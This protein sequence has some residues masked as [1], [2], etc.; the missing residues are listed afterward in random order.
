MTSEKNWSSDG[1]FKIVVRDVDEWWGCLCPH[2][3]SCR[4]PP[5]MGGVPPL[6]GGVSENEFF[7][8]NRVFDEFYDF[9]R[10]LEKLSFSPLGVEKIVE[11][12]EV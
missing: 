11:K 10:N 5:G 1:V 2:E 6:P 8:K 9:R 4:H 3:N 7:E 12:I